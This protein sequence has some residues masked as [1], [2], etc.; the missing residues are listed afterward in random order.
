MVHLK[1]DSPELF[2]FT[3]LMAD[4]Y[5]L[6]VL[7]ASEDIYAREKIDPALHIKT[8]YEK[9]DIAESKKVFYIRFILPEIMI[10]KPEIQ[11]QELLKQLEHT[12]MERS[13]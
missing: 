6:N 11:L 3:L 8:H 4:L 13:R 12:G 10:P 9:L 7:D 2:Q 1:T 5:E